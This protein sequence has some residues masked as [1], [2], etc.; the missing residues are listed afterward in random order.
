MS[1]DMAEALPRR[2]E[3]LVVVVAHPDDESF[4]CGSAIA[5]AVARGARVTLICGTRGE[6]GE[7][8]PDPATDHVPLGEVRE[9]ELRAAAAVLGVNDVELLDHADSGFDGPLPDGALCS[10]TVDELAPELR[11]RFDELHPDVV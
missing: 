3:H 9:G 11:G 2:G 8:V 6:A 4:G 10:L 1:V 5:L 7:R